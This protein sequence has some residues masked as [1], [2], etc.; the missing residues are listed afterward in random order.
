[1]KPSK[2]IMWMLLIAMTIS[3]NAQKQENAILEAE[4]FKTVQEYQLDVLK[5]DKKKLMT[6]LKKGNKSAE[7]KLQKNTTSQKQ[8]LASIKQI[9]SINITPDIS[10]VLKVKPTPPPCPPPI[11]CDKLFDIT[12]PLIVGFD[13]KDIDVSIFNNKGKKIGGADKNN[14]LGNT[15]KQYKVFNFKLD[16]KYKGPISIVIKRVSSKGKTTSYTYNTKI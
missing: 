3:C 1:M 2:S 13:I 6:D 9:P 11:D 7:Q 4:L 12:I 8:L 16:Q 10:K 15:I 14:K 5:N